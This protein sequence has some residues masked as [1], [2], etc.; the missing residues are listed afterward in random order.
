[1]L[2]GTVALHDGRQWID[3]NPGDSLHVPI[4]GVHGFRNES[5]EPAAMLLLFTRP[6]R[7]VRTTSRRSPTPPGGPRWT[8]PT[9]RRSSSGT[10]PSGCS[11]R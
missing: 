2:G 6:V 3:G 7:R 10:T 9:G 1:V 11:Q 5:G 4:G 8:T